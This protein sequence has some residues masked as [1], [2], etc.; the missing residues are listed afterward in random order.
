MSRLLW[1]QAQYPD[2]GTL[3]GTNIRLLDTFVVE[4]KHIMA[5]SDLMPLRLVWGTNAVPE[6]IPRVRHA[7]LTL[8][9]ASRPGARMHRLYAESIIH[10]IDW[11]AS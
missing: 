4:E 2:V 7:D 8:L 3:R 11:Q 5:L 10:H 9:G 1:C 6:L